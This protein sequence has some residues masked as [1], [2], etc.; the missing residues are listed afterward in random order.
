MVVSLDLVKEFTP[1]WNGNKLDSNP[2]TVSYKAPTMPL[3]EKLVP[4]PVYMLKTKADGTSDGGE[5]E[6]T[7]DTKKIILAMVTEIR[8]LEIMG[9]DGKTILI[10]HASDLYGENTPSV[11]SGL[12][13]EI[14]VHLQG[15]LSKKAEDPKN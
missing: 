15:I 8:N 6:I 3:V 13:D 11:I 10:K 14:G 1:E 2:I 12:C 5:M 7:L 9:A 4:K